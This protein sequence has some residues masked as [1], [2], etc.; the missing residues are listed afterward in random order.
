MKDK[1]LTKATK[2]ILVASGATAVVGP[3]MLFT[4][5]ADLGDKADDVFEANNVINLLNNDANTLQY[6]NVKLLNYGKKW[7]DNV[8]L[9]D[10]QNAGLVK[11]KLADVFDNEHKN[12]RQPTPAEAEKLI[13]DKL[14]AD[15][16][17]D[18]SLEFESEGLIQGNKYALG[19]RTYGIALSNDLEIIPGSISF[20]IDYQDLNDI[21]SSGFADLS[22]Y[23][24]DATDSGAFFV[25][26]NKNGNYVGNRVNTIG[27][28]SDGRTKSYKDLGSVNFDFSNNT[29]VIGSYATNNLSDLN[30][31]K[32]K[33]DP[34]IDGI[35]YVE[36]SATDANNFVLSSLLDK[37][38][39]KFGFGLRDLVSYQTLTNESISKNVLSDNFGSAF[40]I[41][42][43]DGK[44]ESTKL[45]GKVNI[46]FKTRK[47]AHA[48]KLYGEN[49]S[50]VSGIFNIAAPYEEKGDEKYAELDDLR[51]TATQATYASQISAA[52]IALASYNQVSNTEIDLTE[53][54]KDDANLPETD[55]LVVIT[56]QNNQPLYSKHLD[57]QRLE[58]ETK[59]YKT[60]ILL[61]LDD[62]KE[63]LADSNNKIYLLPTFG[64][65]DEDEQLIALAKSAYAMSYD[66]K[67]GQEMQYDA[68]KNAYT[69]KVSYALSKLQK[70]KNNLINNFDKLVNIFDDEHFKS[71]ITPE[72]KQALITA[73]SQDLNPHDF[74]DKLFINIKSQKTLP[75]NDPETVTVIEQQEKAIAFWQNTISLV[76]STNIQIAEVNKLLPE[77]KNKLIYQASSET[78]KKLYD[79]LI[80]KYNQAIKNT[81]PVFVINNNDIK[82]DTITGPYFYDN[83]EKSVN[84]PIETNVSKIDQL[85]VEILDYKYLD[86]ISNVIEKQIKNSKFLSNSAKLEKVKTL[87]LE[88]TSQTD[89]AN[90]QP[91]SILRAELHSLYV[92]ELG[93][94]ER[95]KP[96][97]VTEDEFK[98]IYNAINENN[99]INAQF[100]ENIYLASLKLRKIQ[101]V[102]N[103]NNISQE[104]KTEFVKEI[105]KAQNEAEINSTFTSA[106]N[107]SKLAFILAQKVA[108]A[109]DIQSRN[110]F[111]TLS[112]DQ[113]EQFNNY[114]AQGL[115]RLENDSESNTKEASKLQDAIKALENAFALCKWLNKNLN[116]FKYEAEMQIQN[117]PWLAPYHFKTLIKRIRQAQDTNTIEDVLADI[118]EFKS[119]ELKLK[120]HYSDYKYNQYLEKYIG[121]V[122]AINTYEYLYQLPDFQILFDKA[123]PNSDDNK[124]NRKIEEFKNWNKSFTDEEFLKM[125][126]SYAVYVD[127]WAGYSDGQLESYYFWTA[128]DGK[129]QHIYGDDT[130]GYYIAE[131]MQ[132]M[133]LDPLTNEFDETAVRPWARGGY[134]DSC[135]AFP[136][137]FSRILQETGFRFDISRYTSGIHQ[138]D[139]ESKKLKSK[140][141]KEK[142]WIRELGLWSHSQNLVFIKDIIK[143]SNPEAKKQMLI[144]A[145]YQDELE[146]A[147]KAILDY[148]DNFVNNNEINKYTVLSALNYTNAIEAL[149]IQA[150]IGNREEFVTKKLPEY[151]EKLQQALA[152]VADAKNK[153]LVISEAEPENKDA[154]LVELNKKAKE[155]YEKYGIRKWGYFVSLD[156]EGVAKLIKE[157][158]PDYRREKQFKY[159]IGTFS[160]MWSVLNDYFEF[161]DRLKAEQKEMFK[162]P[163]KLASFLHNGIDAFTKLS[164]Y[165]ILE[166][167]A[168]YGDNLVWDKETNDEAEFIHDVLNQPIAWNISEGDEHNLTTD[169]GLFLKYL[170][171]YNKERKS[172]LSKAAEKIETEFTS[173]KGKL[174]EYFIEI[175][176]NGYTT[177]NK[178]V[179]GGRLAID[180]DRGDVADDFDRTDQYV[181][182]RIK[183]KEELDSFMFIVSQYKDVLEQLQQDITKADV[184]LKDVK[185][186]NADKSAKKNFLDAISNIKQYQHFMETLDAAIEFNSYLTQLEQAHA[187]YVSA[188]EALNG[189]GRL[190]REIPEL[191]KQL[192]ISLDQF[193]DK[194]KE[195]VT[196][197]VAQAKNFE[198]IEDIQNIA[199]RINSA[200][201][202]AKELLESLKQIKTTTNYKLAS[203]T[204]QNKFNTAIEKLQNIIL[205]DN[206]YE[207]E[208][209]LSNTV[210]LISNAAEMLNG[211]D[212]FN[213]K[214]LDLINT[215][216]NSLFNKAQRNNLITQALNAT[217]Q[218]IS[219]LKYEVDALRTN[220]DILRKGFELFNQQYANNIAYMNAS[221]QQANKL[222]DILE[223]VRN[224]LNNQSDRSV[225]NKESENAN[226]L[227][228]DSIQKLGNELSAAISGLD[229]VTNTNRII[230]ELKKEISNSNLNEEIKQSL[231]NKINQDNFRNIDTEF[232]QVLDILNRVK[233]T[234]TDLLALINDP[235]L[236]AYVSDEYKDIHASLIDKLNQQ[237]KETEKL[238]S[239]AVYENNI[240]KVLSQINLNATKARMS[241]SAN[242]AWITQ[243]LQNIKPSLSEE[244][245]NDLQDIVS[246][247]TSLNQILGAFAQTN[248][249][250]AD[251]LA[252]AIA[253]GI[254]QLNAAKLENVSNIQKD[255]YASLIQGTFNP[256]KIAAFA[257]DVNELD[258]VMKKINIEISRKESLKKIIEDFKELERSLIHKE[259]PEIWFEDRLRMEVFASHAQDFANEYLTA[260]NNAET[261]IKSKEKNKELID[262]EEAKSILSGIEEHKDKLMKHLNNAYYR[263]MLEKNKSLTSGQKKV[264]LAELDKIHFFD[265]NNLLNINAIFQGNE[266]YN[267]YHDLSWKMSMIREDLP[268][269][270]EVRKTLKYIHATVGTKEEPGI[271]MLFDNVI[272]ESEKIIQDDSEVI[273]YK[274]ISQLAMNLRYYPTDLDG[275]T[276]LQNAI[277]EEIKKSYLNPQQK[278]YYT[279][280]IILPAFVID[281]EE[282]HRS[283]FDKLNQKMKEIKEYVKNIP[284]NLT[285]LF[286]YTLADD[287]KKKAYD[288]AKVNIDNLISDKWDKD[289]REHNYDYAKAEEFYSKYKAT[290][291]ALNGNKKIEDKQKEVID[292]FKDLK[293]LSVAQKEALTTLVNSKQT[294]EEIAAVD[295][296]ASELN[297]AMKSLQEVETDAI[298]Y[299]VNNNYKFA[300]ADKKTTFD[301]LL[302]SLDE[303]RKQPKGIKSIVVADINSKATDIT[304]AKNALNGENNLEAAK[305]AIDALQNLYDGEA[306]GFKSELI[307]QTSKAGLDEVVKRAKAKDAANLAENAARLEK[308]IRKLTQLTTIQQD[309]AIDTI[310]SLDTIAKQNNEFTSNVTPL[311]SSMSTLRNAIGKQ[312]DDTK[313]SKDYLS[314]PEKNKKS[315]DAAV[316]EG[317]DAI[318]NETKANVL[319]KAKV[320]E[321]NAK[322]AAALDSL[323]GNEAFDKEKAELDKYVAHAALTKGQNAKLKSLYENAKT[324]AELHEVKTTAEK[325]INQMQ[326]LRSEIISS[327]AV[328]TTADYLYANETTKS[329]F[330]VA[331][332]NALA[333][334]EDSY[335]VIVADTINSLHTTLASTRKA[336]DGDEKLAQEKQALKDLINNAT[337]RLNAKQKA[338]LISEV[339]AATYL[340]IA[341]VS[342]NVKAYISSMQGLWNLHNDYINLTKVT[343]SIKYTE[344][345]QEFKQ[346]YDSAIK[347]A[348]DLLV[349]T[350]E[351]STPEEIDTLKAKLLAAYNALNGQKVV[352]DQLQTYKADLSQFK[353]LT[354]AQVTY[355][356]NM[357]QKAAKVS[358]A[359]LTQDY[360]TIKSVND[361]QATLLTYLTK[362]AIDS[363]KQSQ[364]YKLSSSQLQQAYDSSIATAQSW[365]DAQNTITT[366]EQAIAKTKAITDAIDALKHA[367][368]DFED[369]KAQYILDVDT[370]TYLNAKQKQVAKTAAANIN[371][372]D[373]LTTAKNNLS[374]LN[375]SMLTMINTI[376]DAKGTPSNVASGVKQVKF[377]DSVFNSTKYI[378]ATD[379][380]AYTNL[381]NKWE[382]IVDLNSQ[383]DATKVQV[384]AAIEEIKRLEGLLDGVAKRDEVIKDLLNNFKLN[385]FEHLNNAQVTH[386][387]GLISQAKTIAKAN[388][389]NS[390]ASAVNTQMGLIKELLSKKS[391]AALANDAKYKYASATSKATYEAKY[392]EISTKVANDN[393]SVSDINELIKQLNAAYDALDGSQELIDHRD[394]LTADLSKLE[395][396]TPKQRKHYENEINKVSNSKELMDSK[397]ALASALNEQMKELR[398]QITKAEAIKTKIEYINASTTNNGVKGTKEAFEDALLIANNIKSD[399]VLETDASVVAT[400]AN[401]LKEAIKALD[402]RIRFNQAKEKLIN[403]IETSILNNAQKAALKEKVNKV[404]DETYTQLDSIREEFTTLVSSMQ[405]L[406]DEVVKIPADLETSVNYLWAENKATY[407]NAKTAAD[408]VLNKTLGENKSA[409]QVDAIKQDLIDQY[410]KLNGNAMLNL[411]RQTAKAKVKA[412]SLPNS[413]KNAICGVIDTLETKDSIDE[414]V[415]KAQ[416][417]AKASEDL[418]AT[419]QKADTLKTT[420]DY[421]AAKTADKTTFDTVL[422]TAKAN[423]VNNELKADAT[424]AKLVQDKNDLEEAMS[425]LKAQSKEF[426]DEK[427]KANDVILAD[428]YLNAG[429]KAHFKDLINSAQ[430]SESIATIKTTASNT[431]DKMLELY[432]KIAD[433]IATQENLPEGIKDVK[434]ADAIISQVKYLNATAAKKSALDDAISEGQ[435]VAKV[436]SNVNA[437]VN[438][439]TKLISAIDSAINALDGQN[440]IDEAIKKFN[441]DISKLT[442]LNVAQ[443][444]YINTQV[445]QATSNDAINTIYQ[446]AVELNDSMKS[447]HDLISDT[448]V[449]KVTITHDYI[450]ADETFKAAYDGAINQAK[451]RYQGENLSNKQ[452]QD[453]VIDIKAK[454]AA[455]N[456]DEKLQSAIASA[457]STIKAKA[458]LTNSQKDALIKEVKKA[459]LI[460]EV[461][462]VLAHASSLDTAMQKLRGVIPQANL[463]KATNNYA[464]ASAKVKSAFEKALEAAT[465]AIVETYSVTDVAKVQAI[466]KELQKAMD[467][468][469]GDK[470]FSQAKNALLDKINTSHLNNA[471]KD[472]FRTRVNAAETTLADLST[473]ETDL[474][475][476]DVSMVALDK[477]LKAV[478]AKEKAQPNKLAWADNAKEYLFRKDR[479]SKTLNPEQGENLDK[480]SVDKTARLLDEEFEKLNGLEKLQQYRDAAKAKVNTTSLPE[481]IKDIYNNEIDSLDTKEGIDAQVKLAQDLDAAVTDTKAA[482]SEAQNLKVTDKYSKATAESKQALDSALSEAETLFDKNKDVKSTTT[483]EQL[484]SAASAIRKAISSLEA[485][486][487]DVDTL[488]EQVDDFINKLPYLSDTQK[489]KLNKKLSTATTKAQIAQIKTD[490]VELNNAMKLLREAQGT[491]ATTKA[492]NNYKYATKAI[493]Q[494]YDTAVTN[495]ETAKDADYPSIITS[496]ITKLTTDLTSV[497]L[498]GDNNLQSAKDKIAKLQNISKEQ[499]DKFLEKVNDALDNEELITIVNLAQGIDANMKLLKEAKV[500]ADALKV[501][502]SNPEN[503][504]VPHKETQVTEL[505]QTFLAYEAQTVKANELIALE[506]LSQS[507]QELDKAVKDL[508]ITNTKAQK[509]IDDANNELEALISKVVVKENPSTELAASLKKAQELL[510]QAKVENSSTKVIDVLE[511]TFKLSVDFRK[512]P[513][514]DALK[515]IPDELKKNPDFKKNVL[516][517]VDDVLKDPDPSDDDIDKAIKII[518]DGIKKK[519]IYDKI[520][521]IDKDRDKDKEKPGDGTNPDDKK[522]GDGTNPD[523]GDKDKPGTNPDDKEKP[524]DGT[525]P[526]QG[527]KEKPSDGD[528]DKPGTNP[529]DKEKPGDKDPIDKIIDELKPELPYN[530][531]KKPDPDVID[532]LI[533]DAD[534][535][536]EREKLR[537]VIKIAEAI[538]EPSDG[539]KD[540]LKA[541]KEIVNDNSTTTQQLKTARINLEEEINKNSLRNTI[542]QAEKLRNRLLGEKS[543]KLRDKLDKELN[544][545]KEVAAN[546]NATKPAIDEADK[547]LKRTIAEILKE[548]N[549]VTDDLRKEIDDLKKTNPDPSD[550]L[551][552]TIND[553]DKDLKNPDTPV[554]DLEKDKDKLKDR[555]RKDDLDKEIE[556]APEPSKPVPDLPPVTDDSRKISDDPNVPDKEIDKQTDKQRLYNAKVNAINEIEKLQNINNAQKAQLIADVVDANSIAEVNEVTKKA[557]ALDASMKALADYIQTIPA[558]L[559][560]S[561]IV[562]KIFTLSE[563]G[564][565][566]AYLD[567]FNTANALIKKES[568]PVYKTNLASEVDELKVALEKA[569]NAL[570]GTTVTSDVEDFIGKL[571]YLSDTQKGKLKD[572]LAQATAGSVIVQI[573]ANATELNDAMKLLRE[574]QVTIPVTKA[575]N[576]YKYATPSVKESYDTAVTNIETAKKA[577]YPSIITSEITKLT[578]DLTNVKL[579]G[580]TNLSNALTTIR[581]LKNLS[582]AQKAKFI[583]K[584]NAANDYEELFKVVKLAQGIDANIK[585]L[586]EAK[587]KADALKVRVSNP[588]N[589]VVPHKE[590]QVT[591]LAQTFSAYETQTAKANELIALEDLSQSAQ[592]LDKALKDLQ[593]TN[594]K[595]QKLIDDVNNELESLISKVVAKE[596]PSTELATSLKKAQELLAQ[597]K[598]EN[599]STKVI[600]VLEVTFKLSV[601]FRKEPIRDALKTVPEELK[602]NPDFKKNVLDP[603]DEVLKDPDPSDDDID[604]AIKIIDDGIKKKPIYDKIDEIDKDRDKDKEKPGTNPDDKENPG[605]GTKPD[606]G[607]KEKPDDGTNPDDKKPGDGTNPDQ[608]DKDKPGTNPDDKEKP[609]DGDKE[610]PGD[611]T[612]P[613]QGD[614]E[615]PGDGD[616]DKPGSNPDDK[617]KPGDK[618]PIDKIIDELKPE[619]PYNP[620]KKPDPDVIDKLIKDADNKL[621]REKLRKVI[622]IAE[623]IAEPSDGLKDRLKAAKEIVDDNSATTQQ[624]KTARI[625]LEEEINKNSLRNTIKQAEKLRNRLLGEKSKKLR[626]KLD[627]DLNPA[628]E[629]AANVNATKPAIDEADQNLKRTIAEI[630]KEINKV[631]DDLRKE[632]DDLKK[633]NPDPSDKLKDTI[634]DVDKDLKNPDTPVDDLEKD[635]DKLK[636]RKRKDDLDK[637]IEKAPEPSK[638]VPGLPPVTDDSRKISDDPNVPDKEIDKQTDK[639]RLYNAKVNAINEIEKL[640]NINNA[641]K[642][643]LKADVVAANS[644]AEVNEITK[645]AKALDASMKALADYIQTIPAELKVSPIVAKIFTLSEPDKQKAYLDNFN[646]ANALI[647]KESGPVYKTNLA[648]EVDELKVALEK[649][650]NALDGEEIDKKIE[651]IIDQITQKLPQV[652]EVIKSNNFINS[653]TALQNRL[654]QATNDAK[655]LVESY[656]KHVNINS[657]MLN[658]VTNALKDMTTYQAEVNKFSGEKF[659]D[660]NGKQIPEIV[661]WIEKNASFL[662]KNATSQAKDRYNTTESFVAAN[663]VK[664]DILAQIKSLKD[665]AQ[666]IVSEIKD[667]LSLL[668]ARNLDTSSRISNIANV[669]NEIKPQIEETYADKLQNSFNS[670]QRIAQLNDMLNTHLNSDINAES[671]KQHQRDMLS[672]VAQN[673]SHANDVFEDSLSDLIASSSA[674]MSQH[675]QDTIDLARLLKEAKNKEQF[676]QIASRYITNYPKFN[677]LFTAVNKAGYFDVFA[678]E[679]KLTKDQVAAM[680][681]L[682]A[683]PAY[684]EADM[685]FQSAIKTNIDAVRQS[686]PALWASLTVIG[687]LSWIGA[688]FLYVFKIKK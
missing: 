133:S 445:A 581:N 623:A 32:D 413:I 609:S 544:P 117:V 429:Q 627:K 336:L 11:F 40:L 462:G 631:T 427:L 496:E 634:N 29:N 128:P 472:H 245:F 120:A 20:K 141:E 8:S 203:E 661:N 679:D 269:A 310:K 667:I 193:T 430:S 41:H 636:D 663:K 150:S 215:I 339:D 458:Y 163:D 46:T 236:N 471:Q 532:K 242:K 613:D 412:T 672:Q 345:S 482:M 118:D 206:I 84:F 288:A 244:K 657:D 356:E 137:P 423:Y 348:G 553:V 308:E 529:D 686:N 364:A 170:L 39:G 319:R 409:A 4:I 463:A 506:D 65:E 231:I 139:D 251:E 495:I 258:E 55:Y 441:L 591:E 550:K 475:N 490:T 568:G 347:A 221:D 616:K 450:E 597:A 52:T 442:Y 181:D 670:V 571:A 519:P 424:E 547:N 354:A 443:K 494:A 158:F 398:A 380:S 7:K 426:V 533:K 234:N 329:P 293:Y 492:T 219:N 456:G 603:V 90:K 602:K 376:A 177:S 327:K 378:D 50:F 408:T 152:N 12:F 188:S 561:P 25:V 361:A 316:K 16:E 60:K 651:T 333:A 192:N 419:I 570:D 368:K 184:L 431:N 230:D 278:D 589:K 138:N 22:K 10:S 505:A 584:A 684:K 349:S 100:D 70:E 664:E 116:E 247:A 143:L 615:K 300:D 201:K 559:K 635:K 388:E 103:L 145:Q 44:V 318:A 89:F 448:A 379:N 464:Y 583:E 465:N 212:N 9:S 324:I 132:I 291:E 543:K 489:E 232:R 556:K 75:T 5:S 208:T 56:D 614:K 530:P 289:G 27:H 233:A 606:Q 344:A 476:L 94:L 619:L 422:N 159:A 460:A 350:S 595:A 154:E 284:E 243:R 162:N 264:L 17:Q 370:Y 401:A 238:S 587:V 415:T 63:F 608:G 360:N 578:T 79:E 92:E 518:D 677:D 122:N 358:L 309:D 149:Q 98:A 676:N 478:L 176:N 643:Q 42:L 579:D 130:L 3:T 113:K 604:K 438:Q 440:R 222:R 282:N 552:D 72:Q 106:N 646:T 618:D 194:Q 277:Y 175:L 640:Q 305:K 135:P 112:Q 372:W 407:K 447:L 182:T 82:N 66:S 504:A 593:A 612:N 488:R 546:V 283:D 392:N 334:I 157:K 144:A 99:D 498:D 551:K 343:E 15:G 400:D 540:R 48:S 449:E 393:L 560:V 577:D 211:D 290:Y 119:L 259:H 85:C 191:N 574:A 662:S 323:D 59:E 433:V 124:F 328:K 186:L 93:E 253:Q 514:R 107:V 239:I 531:D 267:K 166:M 21:S 200:L 654:T 501:R 628:K 451:P 437:D 585:L 285:S 502:V 279:W 178:F 266:W 346:A 405:Q 96:T 497:V 402:G 173:I 599:S 171:K 650:K 675:I 362:E 2:V 331:L 473:I 47:K 418:L 229:G 77:I 582:E 298:A 156:N 45:A 683:S 425:N 466:A 83:P 516:D 491:I 461:S 520:D 235:S 648:S 434:L 205:D 481:A 522:P 161:P 421:L 469:D 537:K 31:G 510:A 51:N 470:Q 688:M 596:N 95:N 503:K 567:N 671:T 647:K 180:I 377:E 384:D 14:N 573:K 164:G 397:Y 588:E 446:A 385:K 416:K 49:N 317:K 326:L 367:V 680:K 179:D 1:N 287:D 383:T 217:S 74:F 296:Q 371:S 307:I 666:L 121:I 355:G 600:D 658:K 395:Y 373:E 524:G 541:A 639:Q 322:I 554:D 24:Y 183:T 30:L 313:A 386:F 404:T 655:A 382:G 88:Q 611:G 252:K 33:Y 325:L 411:Y 195:V 110:A 187:A 558:E 621:E 246:K 563:P 292:R 43:D 507:A 91:E 363:I 18:W 23:P 500:K 414:Q 115:N 35:E 71:T 241:A 633:T 104:I 69:A 417:L 97:G 391:T 109:K 57:F 228:A 353:A 272:S 340:T 352:D 224:V 569:K 435:K 528:K 167:R 26:A 403:D 270:Y 564:K 295:T 485:E 34:K 81:L 630:L 275:L 601:D 641:Q 19:D 527:D 209:Q 493:K 685:L 297:E 659:T 86:G 165:I 303:E 240:N 314:A 342:T 637:E 140:L 477:A 499:K 592:E 73:I 629:V 653:P 220:L 250:I 129:I 155:T 37:K 366:N 351:K 576:N 656:N 535:K 123:N 687:V 406:K 38:E 61:S 294:I 315:Y 474:D 389:I 341:Q 210:A 207:K 673:N 610:K 280:L 101:D 213:N 562:A 260:I 80:E 396:L 511:V 665:K 483:V 261:T 359:Q 549:K 126:D 455:L 58:S 555:K 255:F 28:S 127:I 453:I 625:N 479:A 68:K 160:N 454:I 682:A 566:K 53:I 125:I 108:Q 515:T 76:N 54:A 321:I 78:N 660:K 365:Y 102:K 64:K 681:S 652:A 36:K 257:A 480:A 218:N 131:F 330:D 513:I 276:N 668:P 517:P 189:Q 586:K 223:T 169:T 538:A 13:Q 632:I 444:E 273:D 607:D 381:V 575:T 337:S 539:L 153:L 147:L 265:E 198:T 626:D 545:A 174:A 420:N 457:E 594:T 105:T 508:Q 399:K 617:V 459:K 248:K 467:A 390:Q 487:H 146:K 548:I 598:A 374:A 67:Y 526:D 452:V 136:N 134:G 172:A 87:K 375:N 521:E 542:K 199:S 436:T 580:E 572:K 649:A 320:D 622:K 512:E 369:K 410:A 114:L 523:Q 197:K 486:I 394:Q 249:E 645:K 196:S 678:S 432:N 216:N 468:L 357:L 225:A 644:I 301:N 262:L 428:K 332:T 302:S 271:K 254:A 642:V 299:K 185:Y 439:I 168:K 274:F 312:Y 263:E 204:N 286:K 624:L 484:K 638:P 387:T 669:L 237:T 214:K 281:F 525:K 534:N 674:K 335:E 62:A 338:D 111:R 148:N 306:S 311:A 590:T 565:Q 509:L 202:Q 536:L 227:T 256:N 268:K 151:I 304:N 226:Y 6:R 190:E 605:D 557:K 620:D 142:D